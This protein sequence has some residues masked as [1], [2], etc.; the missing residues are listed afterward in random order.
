MTDG[1]N[2]APVGFWRNLKAFLGFK[3]A[4]VSLR[5]SLE[6]AI[7]GHGEDTSARALGDV[8]REMLFNVLEYGELRVDDVMVP[9]ADIIAVPNNVSYQDLVRVFAEAAHSR[10][11]VFRENLDRVLGMVH[12]KDALKVV[13]DD[14]NVEDF[15]VSKIRRP[16]LFVPPSMK[17]MDLLAKMRHG[18]MH[19][20]IVVDEYG[21][22]DGLVTVEDIVEEIVGEIEDEHDEVEEPDLVPLSTGGYDADARLDIEEMEK[23]LGVD[24]LPEEQDEDV[25]TLGGLVFTLAGRVPEIGEEILH[26]S[27]YKFEVVDADPRRIC[28]VRIHPP[29][30]NAFA[31]E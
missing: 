4:E 18:R 1:Q 30:A 22:T 25:D 29:S 6:E 28:K 14:H 11:P 3:Q 27:G 26:E 19:M 7:D 5:E 31:Q 17:V 20:A 10:I 24:M 2:A 9:R 8:E 12:V 21:G 13:A 16:V 23:V 15:T